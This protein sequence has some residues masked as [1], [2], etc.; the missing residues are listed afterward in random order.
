MPF[1]VSSHLMSGDDDDSILNSLMTFCIELVHNSQWKSERRYMCGSSVEIP[2][3]HLIN[4]Q[5]EI[6]CDMINDI[7]MRYWTSKYAVNRYETYPE[8]YHGCIIRIDTDDIHAGYARLIREN[9]NKEL[10]LSD[11]C[12][13]TS[14]ELRHGPAIFSDRRMNLLAI[15]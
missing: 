15:Q 6:S 10:E 7:E 3:R 1:V 12:T 5:Y 4:K 11:V 2:L 8:A 14:D 9:D 13:L